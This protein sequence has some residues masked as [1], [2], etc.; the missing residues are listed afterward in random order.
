MSFMTKYC[1]FS[2]VPYVWVWCVCFCIS[3]G[4]QKCLQKPEVNVRC[5][6]A[7]STFLIEPRACEFSN[8]GW[9]ASPKHQPVSTSP[10]PALPQCQ[11]HSISHLAFPVGAEDLNI[12]PQFTSISYLNPPQAHFILYY[13]N[14]NHLSWQNINILNII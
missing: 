12:T 9:W 5:L 1:C 13:L 8:I 6:P 7:L 14:P 4:E 2:F 10:I 11:N 3:T